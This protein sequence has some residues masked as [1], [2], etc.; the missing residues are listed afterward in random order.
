[1]NSVTHPQ[2]HRYLNQAQGVQAQQAVSL[3]IAEGIDV[4]VN[5]ILHRKYWKCIA[6]CQ[7]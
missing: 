4:T 3:V 7:I 2:G 1:M 6:V 5:I